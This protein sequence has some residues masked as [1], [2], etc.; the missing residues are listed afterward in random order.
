MRTGALA[1]RAVRVAAFAAAVLALLDGASVRADT[2]SALVEPRLELTRERK[3]DPI[4]GDRTTEE[5]TLGQRYALG[6]TKTLFPTLG[7]DAGGTF[8]DGRTWLRT[9]GLETH[10]ETWRANA[11]AHLNLN[12]GV[13]NG[14]GG[15]DRTEESSSGVS[16]AGPRLVYETW[17]A[18]GIWRPADF[19][20]VSVAVSRA[21]T[22]DTT[23]RDR[24]LTVDDMLVA[25]EYRGIPRLQLRYSLRYSNPLDR[26]SGTDTTSIIQAAQAAYDDKFFR[27]RTNVYMSGNFSST[28]S[29]TSLLGQGG[30]VSTQVPP[31]AGLSL[32]EGPTDTPTFVK[33]D[34]NPALVDPSPTATARINI[35]YGVQLGDVA[36]RDL[37]AQFSDALTKV[38][39]VY[40][41]VNK[42]LP[43]NISGAFT[44]TAY[45]SKDNATW[46]PVPLAGRVVFADFENRFEIP[47]V[48]TEA[49]YL[50]VTVRPLAP[51]VTTLPEYSEILVTKLQFFQVQSATDVRGRNSTHN[52]SVVATQQTRILS[53][54]N[55]SWDTSASANHSGQGD[56]TSYTLVNGLSLAQRLTSVWSVSGRVQ[57][58]DADAGSGHTGSYLWA[59]SASAQPLPT[60]THALTYSGQW[61]STPIGVATSHSLNLFNRAELYRGL[62]L[63]ASGGANMGTTDLGVESRALTATAVASATPHPKLTF[64][65]SYL[66]G[67]T[68]TAPMGQ[69]FA[70]QETERV[71]GSA[72]VTPF[73]S[74]YLSA[75]VSRILKGAVPTTLLNTSVAFS[76][77]EGGDLQLRV[78]Y[79]DSLD[80]AAGAIVRTFTSGVHWMLRP[81]VLLDTS[82]SNID[83]RA[84]A[85]RTRTDTLLTLLTLTL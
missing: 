40:V 42:R 80:T 41:W 20:Q 23:R 75:V 24:D 37:G 38:S 18:H 63:L 53:V 17:T 68:W 84:P 45:T 3:Q 9:D 44:W 2:F 26:I 76:P 12:L 21:N 32:V 51:G 43:S 74:L 83:N 4:G 67:S 30:T 13:L 66:Y 11:Y 48:T 28:V 81:G 79:G 29:S 27:G 31:I 10:G 19:P 5:L 49:Q 71:D 50:K 8:D 1:G 47:L 65:G 15:Y 56:R 58:Q 14:G 33:L 35:G 55:L 73:T 78:A 6:L 70:R 57:R 85:V 46:T 25:T 34:P 60:L 72:S 39:T 54:P 62:S 61:A 36:Y 16:S 64:G 82:Y 59:A 22:F 77:F 69:S 52:E 7:V